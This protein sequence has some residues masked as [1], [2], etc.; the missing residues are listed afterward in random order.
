MLKMVRLDLEKYYYDP[1]YRGIN[2]D[3]RFKEADDRIQKA[4]SNGEVFGVIAQTLLDFNDSHLFFQPPPRAAKVLYGWEMSAVGDKCL[5]TAVKPESD[6]EKKGLKLGDEILSVD[7]F[8]P[9]RGVL[10]K[11]K[12]YYYAL[13][14]K[15]G[16]RLVVQSPGE[17]ARQ[18]DVLAEIKE[19][20]KQ[21]DLL[22]SSN[23]VDLQTEAEN[24]SHFR[25]NKFYEQ[26]DVIIWKM[27]GFDLADTDD[28]DGVMRKVNGHKSLVLD[29]RGN[30]GGYVIML[31]RLL[32]Y[33]FDHDVKIGDIKSRKETKPELAT[34]RGGNIFKGNLVVLID[35]AS[36]SASEIFA[37]VIQLEKRGTIIGDRSGGAVMQS[38]QYSHEVGIG[39]YVPY[40]VSVTVADVLMTDGKSLEGTGVTPDELLLPTAKDLATHRDPVLSR[41]AAIVGLQLDA[42]TAGRLFPREWPK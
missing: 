31:K 32:G 37:R 42:E 30:G 33:F 38:R 7:G 9:S 16:M 1:T 2:L 28:V 23:W 36:G 21:I 11:M 22:S 35:S 27:P 4:K 12:Y 14:P 39:V 5:V 26:G 3:S 29:L 25:R 17:P 24:E 18:L 10:W 40:G 8:A 41:A 34:T 13:R 6:A 19:G 15:P 20:K